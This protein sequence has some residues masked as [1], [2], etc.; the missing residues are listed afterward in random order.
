LNRIIVR[1]NCSLIHKKNSMQIAVQRS[2]GERGWVF[3]SQ[4]PS[5]SSELRDIFI[6]KTCTGYCGIWVC[7]CV[8]VFT[9][10]IFQL[11]CRRQWRKCMLRR[12]FPSPRRTAPYRT[13]SSVPTASHGQTGGIATLSQ[14]AISFFKFLLKYQSPHDL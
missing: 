3:D 10:T 12:M 11:I 4:V 6:W 13:M 5:C 2:N 1:S 7:L 8:R 9:M 14:C